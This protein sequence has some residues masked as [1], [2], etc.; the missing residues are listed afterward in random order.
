MQKY[1]KE[2]FPDFRKNSPIVNAQIENINLYKKTNKVEISIKCNAGV[3]I[4]QIE[5]FE[6]FLIGR[7]KVTKASIDILYENVQI[8]QNIENNWDEIIAYITKKAPF[9]KAILYGSKVEVND[10]TINIIL[11]V[12]GADFLCQKRFDKG[13]EHLLTNVYNQNYVVKFKEN[14]DDDYVAKFKEHQAQEEQDAFKFQQEQLEKE[15]KE[16]AQK[17]ALGIPLDQELPQNDEKQVS[18][19][20]FEKENLPDWVKDIKGLNEE[21]NQVEDEQE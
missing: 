1:I 16:L 12:K 7:F 5:D 11:A 14:I 17:K 19:N 10:K 18:S 6:N 21:E 2:V 13:L 9:S 15:R 3:S 20:E 8:E 4:A